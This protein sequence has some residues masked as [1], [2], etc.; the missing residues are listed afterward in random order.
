MKKSLIALA[1][2]AASGAAMAQ[3]TV[4]L[5]GVADAWIGSQKTGLT[6]VRQTALNSGG[7]NGSRWGLKGTEDLGGGLSANFQLEQGFNLDN[8]EASSAAR[9]FHRQAY[10]GLS[11]GFGTTRFG[12]QYSAYD[13]LRGATNNSFDTSFATTGTVW[14]NG[15]SQSKVV[16]YSG[17]INNQ[18]YYASPVVGGFSGAVGYGFGE[19]KTTT[20]SATD[21]LSLHVKYAAGPLL[22]GVAYQNEEVSNAVDRSY[23]LVAGSYD[24]GVAKLTAGFNRAKQDALGKDSEYQLGVS[25]PVSGNAAVA[26]GYSHAKGKNV[27]GTT[28]SKGS[29]WTLTGYYDLSKRT[30]LYAAANSTSAKDGA[31]VKVDKSSTFAVGMRHSF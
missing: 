16:D 17:R 9:Q 12:R 21:T 29:G 10:V 20:T 22:V 26:L 30:R 24:F 5:Y 1:V 4:T 7:Y 25:V 31:G 14:D 18:V 13:E 2:L 8:G 3:S 23:T 28:F 6:G 15:R 11:G 27:D 19:N